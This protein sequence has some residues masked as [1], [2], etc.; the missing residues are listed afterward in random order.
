MREEARQ[1]KNEK[2]VN[3][4]RIKIY[5]LED[6]KVMGKVDV[7]RGKEHNKDGREGGQ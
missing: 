2:I 1:K 7:S 4:E 5:E 6:R 3:R